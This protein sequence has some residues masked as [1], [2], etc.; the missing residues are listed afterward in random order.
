MDSAQSL[1]KFR[2]MVFGIDFMRERIG[3]GHPVLT[4][5]GLR[6]DPRLAPDTIS[7]GLWLARV[8][9][10]Y[11]KQVDVIL[12]GFDFKEFVGRVMKDETIYT[13]VYQLHEKLERELEPATSFE[14]ECADLYVLD[15]C[16]KR[17][18]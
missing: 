10:V 14:W 16:S 3:V 5:D 18:D 8:P 6:L 1:K 11:R 7:I 2:T 9:E 17:F 12:A 15:N 13:F 4:P